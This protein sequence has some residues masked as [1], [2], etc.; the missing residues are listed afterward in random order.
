MN[1]EI[2]KG[3]C[4]QLGEV[5]KKIAIIL[6]LVVFVG[7][8]WWARE[9]RKTE[10]WNPMGTKRGNLPREWERVVG[11]L[12]SWMVGKT[13]NYG[14]ELTDV[15][16]LGIEAEGDGSLVWDGQAKKISGGDYGEMKDKLKNK[17]VRNI[18]GIK[19]FKDEVIDKL[20]ASEIAQEKLIEEI[21]AVVIAGDFDG[22][23]V[24][25]EYQGD[26]TA[27]LDQEFEM[28]LAKLK[29]K[30]LGELS[31]DIFVNTINKG[32]TALINN[33]L[34]TVDYAVVMGYDFHGAGSKVAGAVSPLRAPAG[35]RSLWEMMERVE[36]AKI[37]KGK[38]V[39]ALPLYGYEW[40]TEGAEWGAAVIRGETQMA[41]YKRAG[42]LRKSGQWAEDW[43]ELSYSAR[44]VKSE[45]NKT[46]QVY[47]DNERSLREKARAIKEFGYGGI[48]FWA[49]GYE[50][51]DGI[52]ER[53]V[54]EGGN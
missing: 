19:L 20:L 28:F 5:T 44:L 25:F 47:F 29:G 51:N 30:K 18:V 49:L 1:G 43:D 45:G 52:I 16:F 46:Y 23:N 35:Q 24:D 27:I 53:L 2:G 17:G 8:G 48:G 11:F 15:V 40:K 31:V 32:E 37:D 4:G 6:G 26:P 10:W 3:A 50:G 54:G 14:N 42:E 22:V 7:L 38:L 41:S 34:E 12:P 39:M 13:Q 33:M 9:N 21:A 36:L